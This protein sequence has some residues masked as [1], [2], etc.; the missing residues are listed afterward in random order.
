MTCNGI[1]I[2]CSTELHGR[3]N[4]Y[5]YD[6]TYHRCIYVICYIY[7]ALGSHAADPAIM[8]FRQRRSYVTAVPLAH[9]LHHA[10]NRRIHDVQALLHVHIIVLTKNNILSHTFW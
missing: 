5:I 9:L 7:I 6:S 10:A 1:S 2:L 8:P 3:T 4:T